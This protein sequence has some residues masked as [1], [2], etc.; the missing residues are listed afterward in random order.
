LPPRGASIERA[1]PFKM[2][3]RLKDHAQQLKPIDIG[4]PEIQNNE[5]WL[6]PN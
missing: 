6:L 3:A 4:Q 2:E 1:K 5:P